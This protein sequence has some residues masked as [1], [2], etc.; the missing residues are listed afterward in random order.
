MINSAY[1]Y[2]LFTQG[3][4]SQPVVREMRSIPNRCDQSAFVHWMR[5]NKSFKDHVRF[6]KTSSNFFRNRYTDFLVLDLD[7]S[8]KKDT[9]Q[10]GYHSEAQLS[11]LGLIQDSIIEFMELLNQEFGVSPNE[12]QYFFSGY[13]GYHLLLP[14]TWFGLHPQS[15]LE[16]FI[17]LLISEI[18][19]GLSIVPFIDLN[20]YQRNRWIRIP[21]SLHEKSRRFKI[22]LAFNELRK[23]SPNQVIELAREQRV[24][25]WSIN[26]NE[27]STNIQLNE[28][29][30]SLLSSTYFVKLGIAE[31]QLRE[32]VSRG[33]RCD[34]A[35]KI[36]LSLR[37]LEICQ[38]EVEDKML[39]WN[40]L[41]RPPLNIRGDLIPIIKSTFS[42]QPRDLLVNS[43]ALIFRHNRNSEWWARFTPEQCWAITQ[44]ISK[45]YNKEVL[46]EN[47]ISISPGSTF[48][49]NKS[50]ADDSML[51]EGKC[52][53]LLGKLEKF[54]LIRIIQHDEGKVVTWNDDLKKIILC[55]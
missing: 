50:L 37:D 1:K 46:L 3:G 44:I 47:G 13:K 55:I 30:T 40:M 38:Q 8:I 45:T 17:E 35:F 22:P 16:K 48:L 51:S 6:K 7:I 4:F 49:S 53:H 42:R 12:A 34:K 15:K 28:K 29:S 52:R 41:N 20:V 5:Y 23:L 9:L 2:T 54:D 27:I 32:G 31:V 24:D 39:M 43:Q 10:G 33:E 11:L 18:T 19:T 21:N 26:Q 25:S 14:T 36:A